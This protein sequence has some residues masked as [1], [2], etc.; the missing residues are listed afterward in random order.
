MTR[1]FLTPLCALGLLLGAGASD[2]R[3]ANKP[4][5]PA[6]TKTAAAPVAKTKVAAP[7]V[8][9]KRGQPPRRALTTP[10]AIARHQRPAAGAK[11]I[12]AVRAVPRIRVKDALSRLPG[13]ERR[14]M[15]ALIASPRAQGS[16][17]VRRAVAA[18][19]L[20][21]GLKGGARLPVTIADLQQMT[22]S[23]RWSAKRM[24]NFAIVLR[25]AVGI[26]Q[27]EGISAN[28]A[29]QKALKVYGIQKKFNRGVC[30]A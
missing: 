25:T 22:S 4:V 21:R 20:L 7:P 17:P 3:P 11:A 30:G 8:A 15:I 28:A 19:L 5:A 23:K 13:G 9:I 1:A 18:Y 2:A 14:Q 6:T 10:M 29:F 26:A 24:Q 27:A 16:V 12:P